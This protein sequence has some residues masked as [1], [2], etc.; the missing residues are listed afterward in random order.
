MQV[1]GQ[2]LFEIAVDARYGDQFRLHGVDED[3]RVGV[4]FR[5]CQSPAA[6][7]RINMNVSVGNEFRTLADD[8]GYDKVAVFRVNLL[9]GADGGADEDGRVADDRCLNGCRFLVDFGLLRLG[10]VAT[11][12]NQM[13]TCCEGCP[14]FAFVA[15]PQNLH[16]VT[17][18]KGNHGT[19]VQ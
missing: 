2:V 13:V 18:E 4:A 17:G 1:V 3:A 5:A 12:E 15:Q 11:A 7:G 10:F 8:A 9:S 6:H 14:I 19:D 16:A